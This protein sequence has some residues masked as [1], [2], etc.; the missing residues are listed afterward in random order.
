M[1]ENISL[2]ELKQ[3]VAAIQQ[4]IKELE[5]L[6]SQSQGKKT[7]WQITDVGVKGF[8]FVGH[9]D[10]RVRESER[11]NDTDLNSFE[12]ESVAKGFA[13]AFSVMIQLRQCEGAGER[14]EDGCGWMLTSEET[15]DWW[16]GDSYL[17]FFPPRFLAK[18]KPL[19]LPNL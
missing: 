9:L 6:P 8:F 18:K 2:E 7:P 17:S 19:L 12:K 11:Y 5:K 13:N 3:H 16:R 1:N 14:G 4:R 15:Y 10:G